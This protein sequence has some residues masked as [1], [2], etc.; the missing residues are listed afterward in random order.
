MWTFV[1]FVLSLTP[2]VWLDVGHVN[3][4]VHQNLLYVLGGF[5]LALK[6][7]GVETLMNRVG[8]ESFIDNSNRT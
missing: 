4:Y 7:G 2:G 1:K 3:L 5:V 6:N 8:G